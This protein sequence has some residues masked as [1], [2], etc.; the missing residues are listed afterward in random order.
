[1]CR[2]LNFRSFM[3]LLTLF[4]KIQ[5][6]PWVWRYFRGGMM[7]VSHCWCVFIKMQ[8]ML[9]W[10]HNAVELSVSRMHTY[11]RHIKLTELIDC[12][13]N[14]TRWPSEL[15]CFCSWNKLKSRLLIGGEIFKW[16]FCTCAFFF[17]LF[18]VSVI[19][20]YNHFRMLLVNLG[21]SWILQFNPINWNSTTVK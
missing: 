1:M 11:T 20:Q 12:H 9:R 19:P 14:Q 13:S 8:I 5:A 15:H 16:E 18:P 7:R 2:R 4:I 10:Y 21:F 17:K 3:F 6:R